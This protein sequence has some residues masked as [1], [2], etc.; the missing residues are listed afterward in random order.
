MGYV[1]RCPVCGW[2]R[3]GAT[4]TTILSP[5]CERCGCL[6][7]A[8]R[9]AAEHSIA[10]PVSPGRARPQGRLAG[11]LVP[12]LAAMALMLSA[13]V[14]VYRAAGPVLALAALGIMGLMAA[15]MLAA[16]R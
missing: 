14:A 11:A 5:L 15:S 2:R 13:T 7:R 6:L 4:G 9:S 1:H 3:A 10:D 8:E 12:T 16:Q